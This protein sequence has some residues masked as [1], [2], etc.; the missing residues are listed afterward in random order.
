MF[1]V[2]ENICAKLGDFVWSV[3]PRRDLACGIFVASED[4]DGM[5]RRVAPRRML[6]REC[7]KRSSTFASSLFGA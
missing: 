3:Q 2:H 7:V 1:D 4:E 6:L 5:T